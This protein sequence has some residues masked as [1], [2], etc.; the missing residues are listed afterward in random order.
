MT[1][2][3]RHLLIC[4]LRFSREGEAGEAGEEEVAERAEAAIE[5]EVEEVAEEAAAVAGRAHASCAGGLAG[6]V[7]GW[8]A[9]GV[10]LEQPIQLRCNRYQG[11]ENEVTGGEA[12]NRR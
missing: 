7:V 3:L 9:P 2:P 1:S 12:S 5:E 10:L 6:G 4:R 8:M 11:T